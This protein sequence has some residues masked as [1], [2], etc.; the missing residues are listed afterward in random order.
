MRSIL[1]RRVI[2]IAED[3]STIA[4]ANAS[5]AIHVAFVADEVIVRQIAYSTTEA[6]SKRV[7]QLVSNLVSDQVLCVFPAATSNANLDTTFQFTPN[8]QSGTY[9]FQVQEMTAGGGA[10]AIT[11]NATGQYQVM[12]EFIKYA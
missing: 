8:F 5:V 4:N 1:N 9:I 11:T 3:L 6:A 7:Y 12:L 10:G 2:N